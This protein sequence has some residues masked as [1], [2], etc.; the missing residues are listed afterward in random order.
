VNRTRLALMTSAAVG[1]VALASGCAAGPGAATL[2][3][4][5]DYA[6]GQAA[7][8][9]A[10]DIVVVVDPQT[11]AAQ[12]TG[13]LVN[14]DATANDE[15]TGVSVGGKAIPLA[16]PVSVA[17]KGALNLAKDNGP[18]FVIAKGSG[19]KP[20]IDSDVDLTFATAGDLKL[21]AEV[22]Q[23]TGIYAAFQPSIGKSPAS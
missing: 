9:L 1:T 21:S 8:M 4:K 23:N 12:L 15:L 5:P 6:A 7:S 18:K 13:T 3:I 17:A 14:T 11:G 20:G 10:Q 2:Q 22:E 16:V 19:L